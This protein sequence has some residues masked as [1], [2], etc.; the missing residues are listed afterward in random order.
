MHQA[1][2]HMELMF[3]VV[4]RPHYVIEAGSKTGRAL[5]VDTNR[6]LEMQC[7]SESSADGCL[8]I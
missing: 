2:T 4:G 1:T 3:V 7:F 8:P 6:V 5:C